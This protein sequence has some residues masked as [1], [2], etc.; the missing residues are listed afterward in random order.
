MYFEVKNSLPSLVINFVLKEIPPT[1][2]RQSFSVF[3]QASYFFVLHFSFSI[4]PKSY[5]NGDSNFSQSLSA[6][7]PIF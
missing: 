7:S 5:F 4:P 2:I 1:S 6:D 3:C